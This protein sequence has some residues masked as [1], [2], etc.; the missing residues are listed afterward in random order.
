[1]AKKITSLGQ[2]FRY[3]LR[4]LGQNWGKARLTQ[5]IPLGVG[6]CQT[7]NDSFKRI[8]KQLREARKA[9]EL[10]TADVA[11][12][13]RISADYLKWLESGDFDQLPAPTYV[14]GFLR[15]YGKF[16]GLDGAELA[17]RYYAINGDAS[18]TVDYKLP[19]TAGPPQRSAPAVASL[20]VV[21][22]LIGYGGWYWIDGPKTPDPHAESELAVV[23]IDNKQPGLMEK[24]AIGKRL[25]TAS[26]AASVTTRGNQGMNVTETKGDEAKKIAPSITPVADVSSSVGSGI[27]NDADNNAGTNIFASAVSDS[28]RPVISGV[29]QQAETPNITTEASST[30]SARGG[31]AATQPL[32]K[33]VRRENIDDA[34]LMPDLD[35]QIVPGRAAAVATVREPGQEVTIRATASSW[36]EIVRGDGTAILRKLMKAGETYVVGNGSALYLSTGNAGGI[37]L[38]TAGKNIIKIGAIGEI[39]RDLPLA[40][41]R[42]R[43]RF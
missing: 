6:E 7:M 25:E 22:A 1:M 21:L 40:K 13:L 33:M 5:K 11:R 29:A 26:G 27:L 30:L 16:L 3:N 4:Y 19:V 43:E 41:N 23:E 17:G 28:D 9:R 8:G 24:N 36:V 31:E 35:Q 20:F 14:S 38:V 32:T 2:V 10:R 37:E 39:V 18:S 34:A 12:E 15:S 42:L